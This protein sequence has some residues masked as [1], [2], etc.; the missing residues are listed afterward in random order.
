MLDGRGANL[1]VQPAPGAEPVP[2]VS[3]CSSRRCPTTGE[4][5]SARGALTDRTTCPLTA[6]A[7]MWRS[8]TTAA[9]PIK[10]RLRRRCA[11]GFADP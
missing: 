2:R 10:G 9:L 7:A 1:T 3:V 5:Q 4:P 8:G 6:G 11:I